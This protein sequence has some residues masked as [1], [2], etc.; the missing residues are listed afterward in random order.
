MR[1]PYKTADQDF[2]LLQC[3]DER[4]AMYGW[5]TN[6]G[7]KFVIIVDMEG[8]A[9]RPESKYSAV[10][11][12]TAADVKPVRTL[13]PLESKALTVCNQAFRA[14][15]TAYIHLL[16]NPFYDPDEHS[17]LNANAHNRIGS[18]QITNRRFIND[19]ARIGE[20]WV[21]GVATV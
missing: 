8:K 11:G 18:T 12:L 14:L 21:P 6:T 15:Q 3:I 16:R 1:I 13:E 17:P 9:A 4:L 20:S 7:V 2:G 19:V 10:L 5:L